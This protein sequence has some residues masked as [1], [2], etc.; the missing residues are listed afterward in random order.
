LEHVNAIIA[1]YWE[2]NVRML[3]WSGL[4]VEG[5]EGLE[6]RKRVREV[7]GGCSDYWHH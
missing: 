2:R 6:G 5:R 7:I 4:R 1:S 3:R